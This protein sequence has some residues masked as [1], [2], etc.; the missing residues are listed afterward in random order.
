[1]THAA[2][3]IGITTYGRN[4]AGEFCLWGT[5][6]DAVRSAGGIPL[7]LPPGEPHLD[8]VLSRVDGLIFAG[9]G[10]IDPTHYGGEVHP[11]LYKLDAERDRFELALATAA[12]QHDLPLLGICRG[13]QVLSVAS[14]GRLIPHVVDVFGNDVVHRVAQSQHTHHWV[15][16]LP[17][18]RIARIVGVTTMEIV[19]WHHQAVESAP[20]G[21]Q[22]AAYAADGLIEALEHIHHPW[23][24]ALQWHPEMSASY[25]PL[26]Q[27]IFHAFIAAARSRDLAIAPTQD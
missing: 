9:G 17:D 13:A 21:W 22:A 16:V 23:A 18:S 3:V 27:R 8:Q 14:G 25:D 26:Q 2:P 15:N 4:E 12:L 10:D 6:I 7:L 20:P 24:I 1:M 5:Y 19:S 11:T